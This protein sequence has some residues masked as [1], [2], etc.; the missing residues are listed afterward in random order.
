MAVGI[1]GAAVVAFQ[2]PK[3]A[4]LKQKPSQIPTVSMNCLR[5]QSVPFPALLIEGLKFTK[6]PKTVLSYRQQRLRDKI[7]LEPTS[8]S[9]LAS[10]SS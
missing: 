9:V 3:V 7:W 1:A 10:L 5:L 2:L 6:L 8:K 4:R